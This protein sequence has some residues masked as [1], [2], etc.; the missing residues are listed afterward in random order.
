MCW[1]RKFKSLVFEDDLAV[2]GRFNTVQWLSLDVPSLR[3][4][5]AILYVILDFFVERESGRRVLE[6]RAL[7][8]RTGACSIGRL[9]TWYGEVVF[10][11]KAEAAQHGGGGSPVGKF[12]RDTLINI[13][14]LRQRRKCCTKGRENYAPEEPE[15]VIDIIIACLED[16]RHP[17]LLPCKSCTGGCIHV[18]N[19]WNCRFA[20]VCLVCGGESGAWGGGC[21]PGCPSRPD[22]GRKYAGIKN[23]GPE[24]ID[25]D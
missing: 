13:T 10:R 4:P 3:L 16:Y 21:L 7:I 19:V 9:V 6:W 2:N 22:A 1:S 15:F 12:V 25:I 23:I 20:A 11:K 14:G 17:V 5:T 24:L 18:W 8:R